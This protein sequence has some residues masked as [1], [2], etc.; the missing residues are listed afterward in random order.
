MT[1]SEFLDIV[2][3]LE[4]ACRKNYTDE[5]KRLLWGYISERPAKTFDLAV[6]YL[7][8]VSTKLPPVSEILNAFPQETTSVEIEIGNEDWLSRC[9][10]L[11][12]AANAITNYQERMDWAAGLS[13]SDRQHLF[14]ARLLY[15]KIWP[16]V[17]AAYP[18]WGKDA[19]VRE[20]LTRFPD[21]LYEYFNPPRGS[22]KVARFWLPKETRG[23]ITQAGEA[24]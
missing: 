7:C 9:R 10:R 22:G 3:R 4:T 17:N 1:N 14:H 13:G 6:K 18:D 8:T 5:F 21:E 12:D 11:F 16:E 15:E 24:F 20:C 2:F 23:G 19:K